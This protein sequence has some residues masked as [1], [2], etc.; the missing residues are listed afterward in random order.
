MRPS[1][2]SRA[3]ISGFL[4]FLA[5]SSLPAQRSPN[6]RGS[7]ENGS[8]PKGPV[9]VP[10]DSWIYPALLRL[11]ALGYIRDSATGQRPW[12]RQECIR[13][14]AEAQR[15]LAQ[16]EGNLDEAVALI[17]S[18]QDEFAAD[19]SAANSVRLDSLYTRTQ[20]IAGTPLADGYNFGQTIVNDYGRPYAEGISGVSGFSASAQA[21]RFSIST[22]GEFQHSPPFT[23]PVLESNPSLNQLEPVLPGSTTDV[24]RFRL[25][26]FYAGVQ[27]G[28][29][30]LTV[31][32][33]DLWWGPG[34]SGPLSFSNNAEP[35]YSFRVTCTTPI[36]LPGILRHLGG[37][38]LDLI[39]G[40]LSGHRTPARPLLNGQKLTWNITRDLEIGFTRWSLFGGAGVRAFTAQSVI[41]NL[42]AN[43]ATFGSAPD[44]G[45][46]K[47]GFDFRWRTP[48]RG[49]T[50]FSD[51]YAD[52][53]PSPLT[54]PT[55]SAFSPGIY[56]PVLPFLRRW[57]LRLEAPSTRLAT[58]DKGGRFLYWNSVYRDAN[59]NRG[60]V[61]GSWAGRDGRGLFLQ[62]TYWTSGRP[63]L[64]FSYRQNRIGPAF[65]AGGGTQED[66][67][68][69]FWFNAGPGLTARAA[70]QYERYRI[71]E[72]GLPHSNIVLSL[73]I[74]YR[75]RWAF[76]HSRTRAWESK[77]GQENRRED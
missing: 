23:S 34:D 40:E 39:G 54:S 28:G 15:V 24:N 65:L 62:S 9:F 41:R 22:R 67:S 14:L 7:S 51:F 46:R 49:V 47:S 73:E 52:D 76:I 60:N 35:F 66:G 70:A 21:G 19:S 68:V 4:A 58:E 27:L 5:V 32:K 10:V 64:Q 63:R 77:P 1:L 16:E 12:T 29:W 36:E 45:D 71:P 11:A 30:S 74:A 13:Q 56:M 44:P 43:G 2:I 72:L 25:L 31:G 33:Q 8:S 42:F 38:R 75:P 26:E 6:A 55:R 61:L 37:F 57:D 59:T 50:L 48:W 3:L 53:E 17:E 20:G 69:A 18:L